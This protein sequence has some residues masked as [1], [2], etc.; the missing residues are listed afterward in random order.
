MIVHLGLSKAGSTTLQKGLFM[1]HSEISYLG[2]FPK[3]QL[4]E[5]SEKH[6][7]A[8]A[9]NNTHEITLLSKL[10]FKTDELNFS[11]TKA[12]ELKNSLLKGLKKNKIP[13][14]SDE[15][16]TGTLHS[17]PD[18]ITKIKRLD[19]LFDDLRIIIIVREQRAILKSFYRMFP[20]DPRLS[21]DG[22][23]VNFLTW[24]N[25][26]SRKKY[27]CYLDILDYQKLS[28]KITEIISKDKV[29]FLPLEMLNNNSEQFSARLS[30]FCGISNEETLQLI[31]TKNNQ[32]IGV[33]S[34][35]NI[36]R[37]AVRIFP[38]SG[39]SKY[40][41]AGLVTVVQNFLRAGKPE[42]I[43]LTADIENKIRDRFSRSNSYISEHYKIPLHEYGYF[44]DGD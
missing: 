33:S 17:Y 19:A 30:S 18:V 27:F 2:I 39:L 10:L 35:Q 4:R 24:F 34:R 16:A 7:T 32:N 13:I 11:A 14:L 42:E 15:S 36:W 25:L 3:T 43:K 6:K 38:I 23:V 5:I 41:P 21:Y 26:E 28:D 40:F 22:K 20:F 31:Q 44:T 8:T 37:K 1:R 12:A 29:L 9:S